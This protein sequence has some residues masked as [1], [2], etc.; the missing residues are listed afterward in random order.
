MV[1]WGQKL[2]QAQVLPGEPLG[3]AGGFSD[4]EAAQEPRRAQHALNSTLLLS[5]GAV[6]Y[7]FITFIYNSFRDFPVAAELSWGF[8]QLSCLAVPSGAEHKSTLECSDPVLAPAPALGSCSG[9]GTQ[10]FLRKHMF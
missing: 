8:V 3:P 2:R 9:E 4:A 7:Q 5:P 1:I 6:C 10:T